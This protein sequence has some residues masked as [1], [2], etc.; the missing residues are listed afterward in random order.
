MCAM[1]FKF[2]S[3][4]RLTSAIR[5]RARYRLPVLSAEPPRHWWRITC[6]KINKSAPFFFDRLHIE[7]KYTTI[8]EFR[9]C[10]QIPPSLAMVLLTLIFL[11]NGEILWFSAM[12]NGNFCS[13]TKAYESLHLML[14]YCFILEILFYTRATY[15][16][17]QTF[18]SEI[19]SWRQ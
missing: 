10:L 1:S 6:I 16:R 11:C 8:I 14:K 19:P 15:E 13:P 9:F 17:T 12:N 4:K 5:N 18:R 3:K 2:P 7:I